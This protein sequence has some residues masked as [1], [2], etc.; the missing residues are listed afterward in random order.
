MYT[1]YVVLG[2]GLRG[3]THTH[4]SSLV[5]TKHPWVAKFDDRKKLL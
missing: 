2:D 4:Y 3:N 1:T 5:R